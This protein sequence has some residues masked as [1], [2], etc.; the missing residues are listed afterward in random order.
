MQL[1]NFTGDDSSINN[2]SS[3]TCPWLSNFFG[4]QVFK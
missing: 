1:L 3:A 4:F 2:T